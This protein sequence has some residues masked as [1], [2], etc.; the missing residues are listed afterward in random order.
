MCIAPR[1]QRNENAASGSSQPTQSSGVGGPPFNCP[2]CASSYTTKTGLGVHKRRA[3]EDE[4]MRERE[5]Q[6][7]LKIS[8]SRWTPQEER[9]LAIAEIALL[10]HRPELTGDDRKISLALSLGGTNAIGRTAESI[11]KRRLTDTY[12]HALNTVGLAGIPSSSPAR[13]STRSQT[14]Q[15]NSGLAPGN[16]T[17][18]L[19][20]P[21]VEEIPLSPAISTP[22]PTP[23]TLSPSPSLSLTVEANSTSPGPTQEEE[24]IISAENQPVPEEA[25][26]EAS[27]DPILLHV[28]D[29][30][31][32]K[33]SCLASLDIDAESA[34][35]LE[36]GQ[37]CQG[38][39]AIIEQEFAKFSQKYP[40][41]KLPRPK[42]RLP[43]APQTLSKRKLRRLEFKTIQRAYK[44]N[45]SRCARQ[46]L[47]GTWKIRDA[48]TAGS[49]RGGDHVDRDQ[50]SAEQLFAFW[51]ETFEHLSIT[52]ARDPASVRG[53]QWEV[54][55]PITLDELNLVIKS[56][57]KN[58]APGADGRKVSSLCE[59]PPKDLLA[60]MNLWL[61]GGGLPACLC[62]GR[63]TLIPKVI[64][65]NDPAKFR[66]ITVTSVLV[67]AFHK[68]LTDRTEVHCPVSSRQKAFRSGDGLAENV[69]ILQ[70]VLKIATDTRKPRNLSIA[71]L[72]VKKAFDSVSHQSM[73][74]AAKRHGMPGPLLRYIEN[75]YSEGFTKL[76]SEEKESGVVKTKRGVR[77][78]DSLSCPLFNMVVDWATSH[79]EPD[80]GFQLV[81]NMIT[82][83]EF[84]DD[85][86]LIAEND[87]FLQRQ[88]NLVVEALGKC[89]LE[90]NPDKCTSIS[91]KA[92]T[93]M[94]NY[95]VRSEPAVKVGGKYIPALSITQVYK[96]LG[97]NF[98]AKGT[99]QSAEPRLREAISQISKAPLRPQQRLHIFTHHAL[100]GVLHTLMLAKVTKGYLQNLDRVGR[101]ALK[102]WLK[103][104][105]DTPTAFFY[106]HAKDGGL[107]ILN[108]SDEVLA[109]K[110]KRLT[111]LGSGRDAELMSEICQLEVNKKIER[112]LYQAVTGGNPTR[113][114]KKARLADWANKLHESCDGRGLRN[115]SYSF[116]L[117]QSPFGATQQPIGSDWLK[118]GKSDLV[119]GFEFVKMIGLRAATLET[120]SRAFR[121]RGDYNLP[122]PYCEHCFNTVLD[123]N[124]QALVQPMIDSLSHR[125]QTCSHNQGLRIR[126]HDSVQKR[127]VAYLKKSGWSAE[128]NPRINTSSGLK[129]PDLI[130]RRGSVAQVI[131]VQVGSDNYLDPDQGHKEKVEKYSVHEEITRY[132][133]N[134][135]SEDNPKQVG[136]S[137][138]LLNW[139]GF[140]SPAS[141]RDLK[142]FGVSNQQLETLS[143]IVV[144]WGVSIW[145][146]TRDSTFR[147][148][149]GLRRRLGIG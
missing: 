57:G 39:Q 66:P 103:L 25:L 81:S 27:E 53:T 134:G 72:D 131:D 119:P 60:Q 141:A 16:N 10:R 67:R 124:G 90:V 50:L 45:K 126:R 107:G 43:T 58:K 92:N 94:K 62:E 21:T 104:P 101:L 69:L 128:G 144:R 73:L 23:P 125:L 5:Q 34:Q 35:L 12:L 61:T 142:R 76:R 71:F 64:G 91:I 136:F 86:A 9:L 14:R 115:S 127:L 26:V 49:G 54:I 143:K 82:H 89:G 6:S 122:N 36:P 130:I 79:L 37:P 28:S 8:R 111:K 70:S 93:R 120:K 148:N 11:R 113:L 77:Q 108:L 30:E 96:Y 65:T 29:F 100:P 46:I 137:A 147:V 146:K 20:E 118:A 1:S 7:R 140:W 3:H 99:E 135:L 123:Q 75:I 78:G 22:N 106:S 44:A 56:M 68:V 32:W 63:T 24:G 149:T 85:L 4:L 2:Y 55:K 15:A 19:L 42:N 98:G 133:L 102:R 52:D 17:Q 117:K 110:H 132:A 112:S 121:R 80:L 145:R 47:S 13:R 74:I 84:C 138:C 38:N 33:Q 95:F 88:M 114:E 97:I 41:N 83:L 59:I 105:G 139:R 87:L 109:M 129:I 48:Q 51:K 40:P 116:T 18:E 31:S